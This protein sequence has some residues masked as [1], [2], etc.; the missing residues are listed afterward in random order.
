MCCSEKRPVWKDTLRTVVPG[1]ASE[2]PQAGHSRLPAANL[3]RSATA[4]GQPTSLV[5]LRYL[6]TSPII[7]RGRE[8]GREY[9][10]SGTSAVQQVDP[11]DAETLLRTRFFR[12][13]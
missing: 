7:V 3:A 13:T 9:L 8:S 2:V 11:R 1:K 6:A 10:F 5:S 4:W 12:R